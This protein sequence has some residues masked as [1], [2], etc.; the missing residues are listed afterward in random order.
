MTE[1]RTTELTTSLLAN[2]RWVHALARQLVD[3]EEAAEDLVQE[4]WLRV[5]HRAP[6]DPDRAGGWFATVLRNLARSR[7]RA[8]RRRRWREQNAARGEAIESTTDV[9]ER[10][11]IQRQVI[12]S[13]MELEEPYRRTIL[14]RFFDDLSPGEIA[15][16]TGAPVSTV[17]TR[18][19]RGLERL[20]RDVFA[21]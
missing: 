17:T 9:I 11:A 8:E 2:T 16:R 12:D 18:P 14:M 7:A 3:S 6:E 19:A 4:T 1:P 20:R 21:T 10:V 15:K 5:L 13:V